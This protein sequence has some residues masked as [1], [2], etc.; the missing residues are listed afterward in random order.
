[1]K[2][3]LFIALILTA[4]VAS[5][6]NYKKIKIADQLGRSFE[7]LVKVENINE[8]FHFNTREIFNEIKSEKKREMID[9]TP[10]VRPEA[11]VVEEMPAYVK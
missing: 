7:I 11:E 4:T 6:D 8:T 10:F 3:L 9:I 5:A 1:M 2:N